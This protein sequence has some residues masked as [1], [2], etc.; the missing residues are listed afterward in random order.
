VE[1]GKDDK[2]GFIDPHFMPSM[3]SKNPGTKT[4]IQ[5]SIMQ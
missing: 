4:Y 1:V 5:T 3:G 2:Y